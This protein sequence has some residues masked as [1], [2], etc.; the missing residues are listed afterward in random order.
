[1]V[2][3]ASRQPWFLAAGLAL[4]G[5][6]TACR[7]PVITVNLGTV[8]TEAPAKDVASAQT[9]ILPLSKANAFHRALDVLLDMGFQVRS[10]SPEAGQMS[11]YKGWRDP[12]GSTLS[13]EATLLFRPETVSSTR[14]RMSAV[15]NWKYISPGGTKGASADVSGLSSTD[16]P[17]GYRQFL[18]RLV[19]ELCPPGK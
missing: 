13:I 16:D 3:S 10:A 11:V 14:L 6:A 5:L 15:G 18:D 19:A 4:L 8:P 1:M 2:P 17:E 7:P 12:S 9:R